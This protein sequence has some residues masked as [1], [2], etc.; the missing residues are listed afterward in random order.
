[1]NSKLKQYAIESLAHTGFVI[2]ESGVALIMRPDIWASPANAASDFSDPGLEPFLTERGVLFTAT[3]EGGK[4]LHGAT[5]SAH[6]LAA[7]IEWIVGH[8]VT[9]IEM[10]DSFSA[11]PTVQEPQGAALA[12]DGGAALRALADKEPPS[13]DC[14]ARKEIMAARKKLGLVVEVVK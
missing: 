13:W 10:V 7:R 9:G 8:V 6:M 12:D 11:R 1:M 3:L 5:R 4:K 2:A 14:P